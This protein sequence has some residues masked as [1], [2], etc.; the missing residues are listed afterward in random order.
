MKKPLLLLLS[1]VLTVS[2][3]TPKPNV[4][5]ILADDLGYGD[6]SCNNKASKIQTPKIDRLAAEGMRFTD[7]HAPGPLCH[8]SRYG[9][10][11]G[12][13]PFR[14]D[15]SRWPTQPLIKEGQTTIASLL[16]DHG[17]RTAMVGKWHLGF[18]EKGYD[19]EL[20]G[21]PVDRGFDSFFGMRA[22]T[23]IPPYFYIRDRRAVVPPTE[24][25]EANNT[26]GWTRHQGAFWREGGIAPDLKLDEVLPRFTRE[27]IAVIED[28]AKESRPF[29][30]HLAYT[31]PHT[32]WLPSPAHLG[33]SEV[34]LYGDF[35]HM[36]DAEV[37]KVL[38]ALE[39]TR[40]AADTLVIFTSDN[41]PVWYPQDVERFDHDSAGELRGMKGD[42]WEAGHRMPFL[43]RWPGRVKPGST[44]DQTIV[45]TD[46]LATFADIQGAELTGTAGPDSFSILPVLE[47]RQPGDEPIRGPIVMR[48]GRQFMMIR[49]GDW[50]YIDRPGSGG[51]TKTPKPG[52]GEPPAQLYNLRK[53]RAERHNLHDENPEKARELKKR[54]QAIIEAAMTR[55]G[56]S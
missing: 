50:K 9:L 24:R 10:M 17:Y 16:R 29:F 13:F 42:A 44:T 41:G 1:L 6:L 26:P 36:I 11:T 5:I 27:A 56:G 25:I 23:D 34:G 33:T 20:P 39:K 3:S 8:P 21:G 7:A 45:F 46:L 55:P 4:L 38:D 30:L 40:A 53:D 19:A 47:G 2:G 35:M 15:V 32:P 28:A 54:M 52:P 12:E 37:G 22:S 49:D 18:A 31:G 51:F 48:S 14:I 43:V